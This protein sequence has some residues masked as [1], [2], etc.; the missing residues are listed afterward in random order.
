MCRMTSSALSRK[1]LRNPSSISIR[2]TAKAMPAVDRAKRR[3]F[4]IRLRHASG[5][6]AR[7]I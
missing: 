3:W 4:D 5:T 2:T 6:S 7:D 1:A